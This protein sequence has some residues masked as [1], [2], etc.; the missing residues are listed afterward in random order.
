M[1][2]IYDWGESFKETRTSTALFWMDGTD[3]IPW[4]KNSSFFISSSPANSYRM[5]WHRRAVRFVSN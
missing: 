2:D 1:I 4:K 3:E 5:A